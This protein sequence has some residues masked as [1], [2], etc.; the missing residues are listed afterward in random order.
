M[1]DGWLGALGIRARFVW[2]PTKPGF[3]AL[4]L[5]KGAIKPRHADGRRDYLA[6]KICKKCKLI[7]SS[8]ESF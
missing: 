1:E 4:S 2:M 8:Y 5:P 6:S 3:F 7:V